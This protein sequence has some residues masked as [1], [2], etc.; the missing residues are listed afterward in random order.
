MISKNT[1]KKLK[2]IA[3]LC[4]LIGHG[5]SWH[6]TFYWNY[7]GYAGA[8]GVALFLILSGYGMAKKYV[9]DFQNEERDKKIFLHF[10][11]DRI[12]RVMLPYWTILIIQLLLDG[13]ILKRRI[14]RK[15]IIINFLGY[16][17]YDN[18]NLVCIDSTMWYITFLLVHY[19]IFSI[20]WFIPKL[21]NKIKLIVLL[22][23]YILGYVFKVYLT[24]DWQFNYF[25]FY[26][27]VLLANISCEGKKEHDNLKKMLG[28]IF[29]LISFFIVTTPSKIPYMTVMQIYSVSFAL[30]LVLL[31]ND[32]YENIF[33][34]FL[35]ESSYEIFLCEGIIYSRYSG[36]I[37]VNE[38]QIIN[39]LSL[40]FVAILVGLL[41]KRLFNMTIYAIGKKT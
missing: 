22:F 8:V 9:I 20:I 27:G 32:R 34:K 21:N 19:L 18:P 26:I 23:V 2:R 37:C 11:K 10:W 17:D 6:T 39:V 16:V 12:I 3:I 14:G 24:A 38:I 15:M 33:F 40:M 35:G 25:T 36:Y 28:L 31:L 29:L 30:G 13:I 41:I 7:L 5:F 1:T 4:V